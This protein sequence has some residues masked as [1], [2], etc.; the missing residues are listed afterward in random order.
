MDVNAELKFLT[1]FTKKIVGVGFRGM[2]VGGC[3]G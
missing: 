2:R 3:S 1:K